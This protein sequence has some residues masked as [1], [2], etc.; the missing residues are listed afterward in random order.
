MKNR[1]GFTAIEISITVAIIGMLATLGTL[2]VIKSMNIARTKQAETELQMI[3]AAALQLAWDTGK[4]P[5]GAW[6]NQGASGENELWNL[7]ECGLTSTNSGEYADWEGPY[8][9]GPFT[10]PWGNDYFF[11]SDYRVGN[12]NRIAVGSFGPSGTGRTA[13]DANNIIVLVDDIGEG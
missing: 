9:E 8:Y 7:K 1:N 6:R 4:W 2:S 11:D 10:D 13:Y 5:N 12:V 3:A